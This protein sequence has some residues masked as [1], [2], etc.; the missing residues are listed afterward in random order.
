MQVSASAHT[1]EPALPPGF[2]EL[3]AEH[4]DFL[5]RCALRMG[6]P[7]ADVEDLVQECFIVALRRFAHFDP[8]GRGRPSTWLFGILRN[9]QRNHARAARRR[10]AR[11]ELLAR[12]PVGEHDMDRAEA[13][14]AGRLLDEFLA[15]LDEDKRAAFVLAEIEGMTGPELADALELNLNTANSRVR[16]ARRAFALHFE[17]AKPRTIVRAEVERLAGERAPVTARQRGLP[18]LA[19]LASSKPLLGGLFGALGSK[20]IAGLM[21]GAALIGSGAILAGGRPPNVTE[22]VV[23]RSVQPP[24]VVAS[25]SPAI[26]RDPPKLEPVEPRPE[27]TEPKPARRRATPPEP[28]PLE[29]LASARTALLADDPARALA[30]VEGLAFPPNLEGRRIALEVAALCRLDR[31]TDAQARAR[32]WRASH[33]DDR[34]AAELIEV[35]WSE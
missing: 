30:S 13:S 6:T 8:R 7:A 31:Q 3:Y 1:L 33:P 22:P 18:I 14:L 10:V 23:A 25:A 35:C 9:V 21:F 12:S 11:L 26:T 2:A 32:A 34:T 19:A 17:E 20:L 24:A 29:R 4:Y 28:S 27:A 16:A 15:S 5:W